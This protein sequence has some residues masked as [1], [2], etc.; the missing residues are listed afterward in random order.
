[1][2]P[3]DIERLDRA[4]LTMARALDRLESRIAELE[5]SQKGSNGKAEGDRP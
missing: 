2:T 3:A 4:D 1:M 5:K